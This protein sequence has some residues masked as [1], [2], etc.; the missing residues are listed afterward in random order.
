MSPVSVIVPNRDMER[1]LPDAFASI[2]RQRPAPEQVLLV[3]TGRPDASRGVVASF[4][5][6]GLAIEVITLP[7]A[8]PAQAR[9]AGLRAAAGDVIGFL[10]ADDL[11]PAGKLAAQLAR[12]ARPPRVDVVSGVVTWFDRLDPATL[13]PAAEGRRESSTGVQLGACLLRREVFERVGELDE[14]QHYS[15]DTDFLLRLLEAQVP[16]TVLRRE[17]LYYRR[18]PESMMS[19]SDE[20]KQRDFHR[21]L[22]RSLKRRG[23]QGLRRELPRLAD[24]LE[25]A[26]EPERS[27][28]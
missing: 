5:A 3:D 12:L 13:A 10:D 2:E 27:D 1:Y 8:N 25:P 11:Y 18:H 28:A 9:N 23:A 19:R 26:P 17:V 15:E 24:L 14:T 7:G 22:A 20:R 16:L 21:A 4:R 6:R